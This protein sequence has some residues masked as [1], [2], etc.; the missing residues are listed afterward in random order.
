MLLSTASMF[1]LQST[2]CAQ[3]PVPSFSM[4]VGGKAN[5]GDTGDKLEDMVAEVAGT[6]TAVKVSRSSYV[7]ADTESTFKDTNYLVAKHIKLSYLFYYDIVLEAQ[8]QDC[9]TITQDCQ[10]YW[11]NIVVKLK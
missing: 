6:V 4:A 7:Q 1:S 3:L 2:V 10:Q 9:I 8:T 5:T 11:C